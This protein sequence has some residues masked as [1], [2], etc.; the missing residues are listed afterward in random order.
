MSNPYLDADGQY[1]PLEMSDAAL[2][3][4]A[5]AAAR[6]SDRKSVV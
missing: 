3:S 6:R 1:R 4:P 2:A 5:Y